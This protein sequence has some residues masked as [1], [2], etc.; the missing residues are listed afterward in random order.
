MQKISSPT[1][2]IKS[3]DKNESS[4]S[5][6]ARMHP[7]TNATGVT[8]PGF[9]TNPPE[10]ADLVDRTNKL[11]QYDLNLL[12][13]GAAEETIIDWPGFF[14][15]KPIT[16]TRVIGLAL[17]L[18]TALA[19]IVILCSEGLGYF[20]ASFPLRR[21][22]SLR[23]LKDIAN[24]LRSQIKIKHKSPQ[25]IMHQLCSKRLPGSSLSAISLRSPH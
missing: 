21:S 23:C 2:L 22:S 20:L 14:D 12:L 9:H 18:L 19:G 10:S 3:V 6:S 5:Q 17:F 16:S 15:W 4:A 24:P 11:T 13:A 7:Y 8:L 1:R 25:P